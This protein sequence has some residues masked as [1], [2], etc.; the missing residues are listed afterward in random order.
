M[1]T[2]FLFLL[3]SITAEAKLTVVTTTADLAALATAVGGNE[4]T[5]SAVAKGTQD[6]HE[7]EAKPSFMV[8]VRKADLVV[9]QGLE[10]ET[11]WIIPLIKGSRNPS[12]NPGSKGFLELGSELD[13]IEKATGAVSRA[14]GDVHP[15][16]NPHFQVDPIRMGRA[17]ILVADRMSELDSAHADLFRKN[18]L[19]YQKHLEEKAKDW[20]TRLTKTGIKDVV[21]YHK[22]LSYF[23]DRFGIKNTFQ[24]EPKPGI[25]PTASHI[26]EVIE[27]MKS[28]KIRLVLIENFFNSAAGDKIKLS[29]PDATVER[30]PVSVGGEPAI[31]TT[32]ELIER[33][34]K[35]IESVK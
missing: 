18:A 13:P 31:T 34:V 33:L 4:A 11:A 5:V 9:A 6:P 10:L 16:G 14:E 27:G 8:Q 3:M 29:V 30:I 23:F 32:E 28:R 35:A 22:T 20:Q 2:L 19:A 26:M 24:L 25:P 1:H 21:T 17:A 12:V 7:I 15:G